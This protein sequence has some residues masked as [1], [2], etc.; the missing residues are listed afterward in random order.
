MSRQAEIFL[1]PGSVPLVTEGLKSLHVL[2]L[3]SLFFI[4]QGIRLFKMFFVGII[5]YP[6]KN[7]KIQLI[8]YAVMTYSVGIIFTGILGNTIR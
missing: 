8:P 2:Y 1:T 3:R 4:I 5:L 6:T 7:L